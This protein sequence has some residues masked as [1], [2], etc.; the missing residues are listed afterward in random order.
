M[1]EP[2][3]VVEDCGAPVAVAVRDPEPTDPADEVELPPGAVE[4]EEIASRFSRQKEAK[5]SASCPDAIP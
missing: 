4:R 2:T 5:L 1:F 3:D